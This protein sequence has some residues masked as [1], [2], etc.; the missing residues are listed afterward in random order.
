MPTF[1]GYVA[2]RLLA[3]V[4]V[5]WGAATVTFVALH[6]VGGDPVDA[7]VGPGVSPTPS[8]RR[9]ITEE[10]GFDQPLIV[11]YGRWL[12]RLLGGDL[13]R[14]Y[15]LGRPVSAVLAD[16]VRPTCALALSAVLLAGVLAVVTALATAGRGRLVRGLVSGAELAVV[17]L[18]SFWVGL[19]ALTFLSFRWH[20]FPVAGDQGFAALVLPAVTLALPVAG[21]LAQVLR[22][23]LDEALT[24][25]F[26]LTVR[27]RGVPEALVLA[28]HALRHA[29]IPVVTLAGWVVGSLL[30]GA[31]L[32][33][34]VFARPGLGRVLLAAVGSRDT[35]VVAAIVL[36]SAAAFTCANLLVDLVCPALDPRLRTAPATRRTPPMPVTVAKETPA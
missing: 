14:S 24:Q 11:Q 12:G 20:L 36:L 17:S 6:R 18:P 27:T 31:V 9:Q 29:A 26:V 22:Q 16:Q 28:R 30:G 23:S 34:T 5:L 3:G 7:V 13:G 15:Q 4:V 2:R 21:V 32:I 35:P 33:E 1:A 10:Y 19:L 8:L 25:P